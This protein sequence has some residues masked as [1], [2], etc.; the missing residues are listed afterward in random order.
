MS[1]ALTESFVAF[2]D[3]RFLGLSVVGGV[4]F[5]TVS[6]LAKLL[7]FLSS[8]KYERKVRCGG[9]FWFGYRYS[10]YKRSG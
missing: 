2:F 10:S 3:H 6:T 8:V 1:S 7:V 5:T 4:P 9:F